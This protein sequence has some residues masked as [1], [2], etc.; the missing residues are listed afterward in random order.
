MK[1]FTKLLGRSNNPQLLRGWLLLLPSQHFVTFCL[2]VCHSHSL[3]NYI[4]AKVNSIYDFG[5]QSRSAYKTSYTVMPTCT[6]QLNVTMEQIILWFK[7]TSGRPAWNKTMLHNI[8]QSKI[9]SF[10]IVLFVLF[11]LAQ[12]YPPISILCI[13]RKF[14]VYGKKSTQLPENKKVS[15][16]A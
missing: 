11:M 1:Q 14:A 5:T 16:F 13:A 7:N 8:L 15:K 3:R 9:G 6:F 4:G 12:K 2:K 10:F